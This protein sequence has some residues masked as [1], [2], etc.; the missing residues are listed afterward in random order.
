MRMG[1]TFKKM[2]LAI[3]AGLFSASLAA[4]ETDTFKLVIKDHRFEPGELTVPAG[5]KVKIRVENQDPT[6]EEFES[7][8]LNREKIIAGGKSAVVF[9]GPLK[10]GSYRFF[11]EFHPDTAQGVL[12]AEGS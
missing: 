12:V 10:P 2:T 9:V 1:S 4:A 5:R 3:A 6:P 7:H 8:D 11:G